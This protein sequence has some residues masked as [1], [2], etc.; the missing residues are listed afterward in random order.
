[1]AEKPH[2]AT[3]GGRSPERSPHSKELNI[4]PIRS[5][6]LCKN[7]LL[8]WFVR[9]WGN[10]KSIKTWSEPYLKVWGSCPCKASYSYQVSGQSA[11]DSQLFK[12]ASSSWCKETKRRTS[13]W[14]ASR[15]FPVLGRADSPKNSN[16][17]GRIVLFK[18]MSLEFRPTNHQRRGSMQ[19]LITALPYPRLHP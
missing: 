18:N 8:S 2:D 19:K 13:T 10:L 9:T 3:P 1:M 15:N 7:L 6:K 5:N 17:V 4:V 14:I 12:A 11:S 16:Q